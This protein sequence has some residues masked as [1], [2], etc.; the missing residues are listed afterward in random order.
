MRS[1]HPHFLSKLFAGVCWMLFCSAALQAQ[2]PGYDQV[3]EKI[4]KP[5]CMACHDSRKSGSARSGA[6][7]TVNFDTYQAALAK[8]DRA[9]A[10][11]QAGTMPPSGG[12]SAELKALMQSWIDAG[13]PEFTVPDLPTETTVISDDFEDGDAAGWTPDSADNWKVTDGVYHVYRSAAYSGNVTSSFADIQSVWDE[14]WVTGDF[15]IEAMMGISPTAQVKDPDLPVKQWELSGDIYRRQYSLC[16]DWQDG[17]NHYMA[18]FYGHNWG[19]SAIY[20][21][22]F[23]VSEDGTDTTSLS[24]KLYTPVPRNQGM[25]HVIQ[26]LVPIQV[27]SSSGV[28]TVKRHG[29]IVYQSADTT[30]VPALTGGK[31]AITSRTSACGPALGEIAIKATAPAAPTWTGPPT[32]DNFTFYLDEGA[33]TLVED[34]EKDDWGELELGYSFGWKSGEWVDEGMTAGNKSYASYQGCIR[35]H[36]AKYSSQYTLEGI[37]KVP[38]PT[39]LAGAGE[40]I[41]LFYGQIQGN[42]DGS[43]PAQQPEEPEGAGWDRER[44]GLIRVA[45]EEGAGSLAVSTLGGDGAIDGVEFSYDEWHHVALVRDGAAYTLYL[46]GEEVGFTEDTRYGEANLYGG[47]L[48]I[49]QNTDHDA[50][51]IIGRAGPHFLVDQFRMTSAVLEPYDFIGGVIIN[52]PIVN[53]F[54]YCDF[55]GD[56]NNTI[57]DVI[58]LL[59]HM[60]DNPGDPGGDFNGD[61]KVGITDA[62]AMLLA[63]RDGT[64]PDAAAQ[65]ASSF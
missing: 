1:K 20:K 2:A 9:N 8:A 5:V 37:F 21:K 26:D 38:E 25:G 6:P 39:D 57:S 7:S 14:S 59:I 27:T 35:I 61:G 40:T 64:C 31:V 12:L 19:G 29:K 41:Q 30:S 47:T 18:S 17:R 56:G 44:G 34:I 28:M 48:V 62:I 49:G 54:R 52:G 23:S 51:T 50:M 33:G 58:A 24:R 4:F 13:T 46:D 3:L 63:M 15:T 60:R 55:N 32:R 16:W 22:Y 45:V 11:I 36:Y 53:G 10:R 65:Q 43:W 42:G